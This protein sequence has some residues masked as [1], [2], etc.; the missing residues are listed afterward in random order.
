MQKLSN[1]FTSL[2]L[3][4]VHKHIKRNDHEQNQENNVYNA[5]QSFTFTQYAKNI[6]NGNDNHYDHD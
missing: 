1:V 3:W 2:A 6:H 5:R 4:K